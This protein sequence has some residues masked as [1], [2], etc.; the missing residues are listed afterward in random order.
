M[1]KNKKKRSAA[2]VWLGGVAVL[3]VAIALSSIPPA[4]PP[5]AERNPEILAEG[6]ELFDGT[7][8]SCHGAELEGTATGPSFLDPIYAPNHHGDEAF[9]RAAVLGVVPHHWTFGPMPAQVDL[10]REEV[11]AI[12]E[13]VRAEQEAAGVFIDPTH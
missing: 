10:S 12:V 9:Q 13:Y 7:C 4:S 2:W 8:A 3:V 1:S 5:P 11:A 6:K